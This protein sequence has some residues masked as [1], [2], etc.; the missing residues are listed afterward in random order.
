MQC[1]RINERLVDSFTYCS[2]MKVVWYPLAVVCVDIIKARSS[3]ILILQLAY[4]EDRLSRL[5]LILYFL[6]VIQQHYQTMH[7]AQ[8]Y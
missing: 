2:W 8:N 6:H 4:L 7:Y 3:I 1:F 5:L